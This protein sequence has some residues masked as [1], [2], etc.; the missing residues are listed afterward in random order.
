MARL[1]SSQ[2]GCNASPGRA[3]GRR[4]PSGSPA[5]AGPA[6]PM[7]LCVVRKTKAAI[8]LTQAKL[9]REAVKNGSQLQPQTLFYA[10]FVLVL[11]TFAGA[12][13][14]AGQVLE[15]Y[16]CRWQIEWVFKRLKQIVQLGHLPKRPDD[17]AQAWLYGK[18]F[19]ALLTEELLAHARAISHLGRRVGG[20][21]EG[22]PVRGGHLAWPLI[23]Y[24]G[25]LSR[26]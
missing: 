19:V 14:S 2:S 7:R 24:S 22:H 10:Q 17:R 5:K 4:G 18:V 3:N 11:S 13:F 23:K 12:A 9:R 6:L 1:L 21:A 20:L 25:P 26:A 8:A 16:R 15:A